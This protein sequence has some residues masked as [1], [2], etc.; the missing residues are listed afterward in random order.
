MKY[1]GHQRFITDYLLQGCRIVHERR[2]A[3]VLLTL[4][5][6]FALCWF[7]YNVLRV[8]LDLGVISKSSLL[9]DCLDVERKMWGFTNG[10]FYPGK[11]LNC[12]KLLTANHQ[13]KGDVLSYCLVFGHGNSML[14][15]LVYCCMTRTFRRSISELL[16]Q[17]WRGITK[18]RSLRN[19]KF[20]YVLFLYTCTSHVHL[21][22]QQNSCSIWSNVFLFQREK[23]AKCKLIMYQTFVIEPLFHMQGKFYAG[24]NI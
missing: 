5:V 3:H 1:S 14:N 10:P 12:I 20:I 11:R 4:A 7:P 22:L 17:A 21:S 6:L 24:V 18:C 23:L 8:L 13:L 16:R 19:V 15:P 2:I 9:T